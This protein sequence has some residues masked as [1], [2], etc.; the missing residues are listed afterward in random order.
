MSNKTL[1][2]IIIVILLAAGGFALYKLRSNQSSMKTSSD[3][4]SN[5]PPPAAT[6]EAA[7]PACQR[8]FDANKL[9]TAQVVLK[10][11]QVEI[12][13]KDFGKIDI[14]FYDQDTPKTVENFL[15]L[16]NAGYYDCLTFHR[17]SKGFVVQGGDPTGTGGGGD[18][19]FGG[20]FADELNPKT[21]SYKTGYVKGVLAMAKA[22]PN[23][24]T[25]QFFIL[26]ADAPQLP[27]QYTIFGKS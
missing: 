12:T 25:S 24:K 6:P 2:I 18:S 8:D 4:T 21:P 10:N 13:V 20:Q 23:T 17:I 27:K 7:A 5:T 11:R 15:R 3:V 22:R 19:A 1:F 26:L 16:T 14:A 9:K